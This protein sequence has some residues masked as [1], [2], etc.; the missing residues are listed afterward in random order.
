MK[1]YNYYYD[2]QPIPKSQ[3]LEAVPE[4]WGKDVN[5]FGEYSWGYYRANLIEEDNE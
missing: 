2:G 4:D 1:K 3:F 5:E